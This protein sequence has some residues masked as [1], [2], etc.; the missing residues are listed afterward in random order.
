V[1]KKTS[2]VVVMVTAP[3]QKTA[4]RL[5]QAALDCRAAACVNL[6]PRV[7]SRYLWQGKQQKSLETLLLFKTRQARLAALQ[8]CIQEHHP[9][10]TPEFIA[11]PIARGATTYLDWIEESTAGK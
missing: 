10:D 3:N 2:F 6:V 9:Y 7:E 11:L 4:R 1:K 5:A 8:R